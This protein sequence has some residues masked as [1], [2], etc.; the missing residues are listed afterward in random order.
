MRSCTLDSSVYLD[1]IDE[2]VFLSHKRSWA[3]KDGND[4]ASWVSG[5]TDLV[6][7]TAD[8]IKSEIEALAETEK[9]KIIKIT[10]TK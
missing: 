5:S 4:Y 7:A 3:T 1:R 9:I 6:S 8:E 10:K 2:T